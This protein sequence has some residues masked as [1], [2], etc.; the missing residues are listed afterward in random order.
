[1]ATAAYPDVSASGRLAHEQRLQQRAMRARGWQQHVAPLA[2]HM[3]EKHLLGVIAA[4]ALRSMMAACGNVSCLLLGAAGWVDD[5]HATGPGQAPH[6]R[7]YGERPGRH[8]FRYACDLRRQANGIEGAAHASP[9]AWD[10][11]R[12][13][14]C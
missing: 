2:Q 4:P 3:T 5:G 7:L 12:P 11:H 14:G 8:R 9:G 10:S 13:V 6:L 1:M